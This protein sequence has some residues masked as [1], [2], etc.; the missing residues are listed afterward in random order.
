VRIKVQ[1]TRIY[2]VSYGAPNGNLMSPPGALVTH[3]VNTRASRT[4]SFV[5][6]LEKLSLKNTSKGTYYMSEYE[7]GDGG[8]DYDPD[9]YEDGYSGMDGGTDGGDGACIGA[10]VA[11]KQY[12]EGVGGPKF[13]DL[14][15]ETDKSAYRRYHPN[16]LERE[17]PYEVIEGNN[18]WPALVDAAAE[19]SPTLYVEIP[20]T[21]QLMIGMGFDRRRLE[22]TWIDDREA[23]LKAA[24]M[25]DPV[26]CPYT[27]PSTMETP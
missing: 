17:A 13:E 26:D 4:C 12:S 7:Y 24:C 3:V 10:P 5:I 8:S 23:C 18:A 22:Q 6:T 20:G 15:S 27:P 2:S 21:I 16:V 19:T 11:E 25:M 9:D 1:A 14:V